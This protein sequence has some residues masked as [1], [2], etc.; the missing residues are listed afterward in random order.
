[1][2]NKDITTLIEFIHCIY[3]IDFHVYDKYGNCQNPNPLTQ[4]YIVNHLQFVNQHLENPVISSNKSGLQ[5]ITVS[6]VNC[7]HYVLGPYLSIAYSD[8]DIETL[9]NNNY[10]NMLSI[11]ERNKLRDTLSSL[12]ILEQNTTFQYSVM[13]YYAVNHIKVPFSS[14]VFE[15][16]TIEDTIYQKDDNLFITSYQ[17][18]KQT[19]DTIKN[20]EKANFD[21]LFNYADIIR[22]RNVYPANILRSRKDLSLFF[23]GLSGHAAIEAGLD[24][25]SV[26]SKQAHYTTLIEDAN[27][28]AKIAE[29]EMRLFED[30]ANM[31]N[32]LL[33]NNGHSNFVNKVEAYINANIYSS[34]SID[35]LALSMNLSKYY[36]TK[37]FYKETKIKLIDY[38]NE[39]KM[40]VAKDLLKYTNYSISEISDQLAYPNLSYFCY[41]FKQINN[42]TCSDY[43]KNL[44]KS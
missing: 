33:N 27:S 36:L 8:R 44:T 34:I 2:I 26:Y 40:E 41:L 5:Y 14:I 35:E 4:G 38:I 25:N 16:S 11:S 37:R 6:D 24:L 43:R 12:P 19:Y 20:G 23:I 30:F 28:E 21:K 1:M 13:L 17:L 18:E 15:K 31:T 9:L 22:Y 32:S 7:D 39:Q 3:N 42:V 29:I 10:V